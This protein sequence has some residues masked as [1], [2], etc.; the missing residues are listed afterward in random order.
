MPN[1]TIPGIGPVDRKYAIAGGASI[2]VIAGI[3]WWRYKN[4]APVETSGDGVPVD[5]T[6]GLNETVDGSPAV[7]DYVSPGGSQLPTVEDNNPSPTTNAEWT[8]QA[9]A[10][11]TDN[12]YDTIAVTTALGKYFA[13]ASLTASQADI[14]R[15][16]NAALGPPPV[17]TFTITVSNGSTTTTP[18]ATGNTSIKA[19]TGLKTW[20]NGSTRLTVPLQWTKVANAVGYRI[21]RNGVSE[22][23]GHS[24]DTKSTVGGL[25]PNTTYKFHVRAIDSNGKTGPASGVLTVKTKK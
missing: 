4:A 6:T 22:N 8:R 2:V 19:P 18:P 17:G 25:Q 15:V 24:V 10:Y 11:L 5:D 1:V 20:G 13:R 16:A 7:S 3:A 12:G 21:Y 9:I 14:V 23:I